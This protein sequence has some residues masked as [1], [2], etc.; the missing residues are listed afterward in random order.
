MRIAAFFVVIEL[1]SK[2]LFFSLTFALIFY[3]YHLYARTEIAR[4]E[5]AKQLAIE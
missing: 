4:Y 5:C 1:S 2:E 3:T